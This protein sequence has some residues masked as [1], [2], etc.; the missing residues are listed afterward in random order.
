MRLIALVL[1]AVLAACGPRAVPEPPDPAP[2]PRPANPSLPPAPVDPELSTRPIVLCFVR[3]GELRHIELRY[4]TATGD[5]LTLDRLPVSS[6]APL[7]GEYASVAGWYVN[8]EPIRF[9]DRRYTKYGRPRFLGVNE[10]T[11]A[12]AIGRVPA[13]VAAGDTA[14]HP[15]IYLPTRPGC[16]FQPY[17]PVGRR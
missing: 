3:A 8:E 10:V 16:E 17:Q 1:I 5:S 2:A 15:V 9:R 11:R 12:G 4:M 13:F 14:A 6:A 7:T